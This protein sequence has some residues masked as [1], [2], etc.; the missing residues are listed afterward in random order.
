[1]LFVSVSILDQHATVTAKG[2]VFTLTKLGDAKLLRNGKPLDQPAVLVH[3]DR[4]LFGASQYYL[5]ADPSKAKPNEP[6]WTFE[7]MQDEI[8]KASGIISKD[9]KNMTQGI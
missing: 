5:F 7:G 2:G 1:M 6:Y 4:L 3:L 8:A 9:T